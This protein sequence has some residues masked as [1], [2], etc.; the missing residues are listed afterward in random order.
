MNHHKETTVFEDFAEQIFCPVQKKTDDSNIKC[1]LSSGDKPTA[2]REGYSTL[3]SAK[4][5]AKS[6]V[7]EEFTLY[8]ILKLER[9]WMHINIFFILKTLYLNLYT[10]L[11]RV[12]IINWFYMCSSFVFDWNFH[13]KR[14]V[15]KLYYLVAVLKYFN[16]RF[17]DE[18]AEFFI[19]EEDV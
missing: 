19:D 2:K 8:Y 10:P 6:K 12:I 14:F 16:N 9:N 5:I 7:G 13:G 17:Y 18:V 15:V 4:A 1:Q 11:I 3:P